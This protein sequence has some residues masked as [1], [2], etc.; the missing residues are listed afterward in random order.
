VWFLGQA[1]Y[2]QANT[3]AYQD[4]FLITALACAAALVPAWVLDRGRQRSATKLVAKPAG[5]AS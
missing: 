4:C 1:V 3:I 2:L 5:P